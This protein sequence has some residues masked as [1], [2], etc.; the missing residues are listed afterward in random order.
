MNARDSLSRSF[1]ATRGLCA[2]ALLATVATSTSARAA[3]PKAAAPRASEG[4]SVS[5]DNRALA[6]VLF[7]TARGMMEAQRY[8]E[9]CQK[10]AESYRLDPA[11]GTL[12]NLAVCHEK[13]GR[14]ASAWGEFT[15]SANDAK[16]AG[17]ADREELAREHA[18][19]L[20]P[21]LPMMTI[22]VPKAIKVADLELLRNGVTLSSAA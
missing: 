14:I 4:A 17:R 6:E 1:R 15:Q 19:A 20:E 5:T 8:P 11:A 7:F 18:A 13:Q 3:D 12:L 21:D 22:E 2:L 10:L 9:A 16:H